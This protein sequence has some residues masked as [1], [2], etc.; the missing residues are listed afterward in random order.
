LNQS[1]II[2]AFLAVAFVVFITQRGELG[3][4]LGFFFGGGSAPVAPA[5]S[6]TT[7]AVQTGSNAPSNSDVASAASSVAEFAPLLLG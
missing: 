6:S 5:A 3:I 4:Y 1:N 2:A 7:P